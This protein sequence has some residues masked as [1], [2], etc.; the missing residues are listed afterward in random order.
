ML[1]LSVP[2]TIFTGSPP[3]SPWKPAG[4]IPSC[5]L[6][7]SPQT[8]QDSKITPYFSSA[9]SGFLTQ[10]HSLVLYWR[11]SEGPPADLWSSLKFSSILMNSCLSDLP[12]IST[13]SPNHGDCQ[14]LFRLP[15][16]VLWP[17]GSKLGQPQGSFSCITCCPLS[18]NGYF[19]TPRMVFYLFKEEG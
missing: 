12:E 14:A 10:V 16:L 15:L 6:C 1:T 19:N 8:A 5:L 4:L 17:P 7:Q 3:L 13:L 9:L 18:E 2:H 11:D